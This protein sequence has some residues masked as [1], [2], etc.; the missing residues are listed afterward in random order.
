MNLLVSNK[1][2]IF[3]AS[4]QTKTEIKQL[5][6]IPNPKYHQLL[7]MGNRRALYNVPEYFRY[8]EEQDGYLAIGRG[9]VAHVARFASEINHRT[10]ERA[11]ADGT[12]AGV[13]DLR[14]YQKGAFD[15]IS[16]RACGVIQLGTGF[17]KTTAI[18]AKLIQHKGLSTLLIVPRTHIAHQFAEAFKSYFGYE[19]GF[20]QGD[21]EEVKDVSVGTFQTLQSRPN[22]RKSLRDRFGMVI[23][24]ECHTAVTPIRME[25]IES[26]AP[27]CLFGM[28][29]TARRTDGQGKAIQFIFGDI[30]VSEKLPQK[31]PLVR[32]APYY[33]QII[34]DEYALM[35]NAQIRREERNLLIARLAREEMLRGRK[36]LILTKRVEHYQYL[37]S[38][39]PGDGLHTIDSKDSAQERAGLLNSLR[40]GRIEFN[41]LLGTYSML[42]TGTDIPILDTLILA[43]DVKS[44]ILTEQSAGRILRIF[45]GKKDPLIIDINDMGNKVFY[46]Q[47]IMRRR[48]YKKMGWPIEQAATS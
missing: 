24:D 14:D 9:N 12:C 6:T 45:E 42:S 17:G 25:I 48:F 11:I 26:F 44:D 36:V 21:K 19:V 20:I 34:L 23:V 22:L 8:Y 31:T 41:A 28:T 33:G 3:D 15:E 1:L 37:A 7:R 5:L 38:L 43:G 40:S 10:S 46:V 18:A 39:L 47:G 16:R 27:K 32:M 2:Y 30:I 29:A 13:V 35:V 4:P